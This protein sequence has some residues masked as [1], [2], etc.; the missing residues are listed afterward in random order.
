VCLV[1]KLS[2][3]RRT[4]SNKE[5][6]RF[7]DELSSTEMNSKYRETSEAGLALSVPLC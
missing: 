3:E 4:I 6:E 2:S 1:T 7:H 5:N